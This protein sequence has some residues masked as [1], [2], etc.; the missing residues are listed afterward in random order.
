VKIGYLSQERWQNRADRKV[1]EEF[2]EITKLDETT[3]RELL[4]R[5]RIT[6][7]DVKKHVSLLSPGEYSRLII[8]ELVAIRPNCIILDEPSN[9]LD[10]EALEELENGLKDYKGT[11][12][13]VSHDRYFI[14]KLGLK[15]VFDLNNFSERI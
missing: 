8:A 2:L 12:I 4:N 9:H 1:I 7:E 13:V 14:E 11:L 3:A 5:F 6:T 10:L 15:N